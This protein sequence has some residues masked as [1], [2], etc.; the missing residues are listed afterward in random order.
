MADPPPSQTELSITNQN[1]FILW[2]HNCY[3]GCESSWHL[4]PQSPDTTYLLSSFEDDLFADTSTLNAKDVKIWRLDLL[5]NSDGDETKRSQKQG[6]VMASVDRVEGWLNSIEKECEKVF[7]GE[8]PP[9]SLS[10]FC[11]RHRALR[12]SRECS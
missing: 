11:I 3:I 7:D 9:P 6:D 10:A 1:T 8:L 2:F 5:S 4:I 12:Q